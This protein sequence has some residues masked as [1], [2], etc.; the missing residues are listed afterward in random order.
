MTKKAKSGEVYIQQMHEKARN[1]AQTRAEIAKVKSELAPLEQV[2]AIL[3][4]E[5]IHIL[6]KLELKSVTAQSG[7]SYHITKT[8]SFEF[9]NDA[10]GL[11]ELAYAKEHN[12]VRPDKRAVTQSLRAQFEKDA[13]PKDVEAFERQ[14]ITVKKPK[15]LETNN[16]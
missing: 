10:E 7:E 14:G 5:L 13:L 1:L 6:N 9:K 3:K 2:E 12:L 11:R 16:Q 4:E 15:E 8:Y